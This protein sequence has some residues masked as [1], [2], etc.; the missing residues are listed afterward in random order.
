MIHWSS[1]YV[2]IPYLA[3]GR[4][5][6]GVD[7]WGLIRLVYREQRGIDLPLLPGLIRNDRLVVTHEIAERCQEGWF[8]MES[9]AEFYAVA[10]SQS[11]AIHHGGV[12]TSADGGKIIHCWDGLPVCADS[13][14]TLR[15]KGLRVI[16]FLRYGLDN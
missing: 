3:G 8:P 5:R 7:C 13:L 2:G 9:P 12:W 1:R 10:M 11:H 4:E 14:K 16:K 15:L 6:D